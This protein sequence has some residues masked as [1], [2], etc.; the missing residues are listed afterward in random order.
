VFG[1]AEYGETTLRPHYHLALLGVWFS[2]CV[3]RGQSKTG[4]PMFESETLNELWGLGRCTVQTFNIHAAKYMAKYTLAKFQANQA[5]L[6]RVL[7]DPVTGETGIRLPPYIITPK[8]PAL[9]I[10]WLERFTEDVFGYDTIIGPDGKPTGR[11]AAYDRW[12]LAADP[13]RFEGIKD[14]RLRAAM[15]GSKPD[16]LD[17]LFARAAIMDA[18]SRRF[19]RAGV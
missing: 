15:A 1:C 13:V 4:L 7:I 12:L 16:E 10:P 2:D 8:R 14:S 3:K 11:V 9:G 5:E 17:R 6:G 19:N 18:A